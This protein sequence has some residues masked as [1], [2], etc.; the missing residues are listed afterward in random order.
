ML[1]ALL[2]GALA[3]VSAC[4][5]SDGPSSPSEPVASCMSGQ[6]TGPYP[7]ST[8][9]AQPVGVSGGTFTV[10]VTVAG[11]CQWTV[12]SDV[13]WAAVSG[14]HT[15]RGSQNLSY[16]VPANAGG[17]RTGRLSYSFDSTKS[18]YIVQDGPVTCA[19]SISPTARSFHAQRSAVEVRV[20]APTGCKWAFEG[21]GSWLTVV[22]EDDRPSPWGDGNG[23][24]VAVASANTD[25][26][27]RTGTA[28][29]AGTTFTATQDGTAAPACEYAFM[30]TT[31]SFPARGGSGQVTVTTGADC[32]WVHDQFGDFWIKPVASGQDFR[33]PGVYQ[34]TVDAN[35]STESRSGTFS[36]SGTSASSSTR[37]TVQQAGATCVYTVSPPSSTWGSGGGRAGVSVD[38]R[39]G[40]CQW[41]AGADQSWMTILSGASGTGGGL[42]EFA[43][44]ALP[45]G[46]TSTRTGTVT[47]RGV[48]GLN[49]PAVHAVTQS[50][51]GGQ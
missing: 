31:H 35:Y 2:S 44:S 36:L 13:P 40:S 7:G 50:P 48:S 19:S 51:S 11:N 28:T 20:F 38:A 15:F 24:V 37:V 34:F 49:P 25:T 17:S 47:V 12:T 33:G 1:A 4:D 46:T 41:T 8:S 43:V 10:S 21:N 9:Q 14:G 5:D 39:P 6:L 18:T 30:P 3:A 16:T 29:I 27:P 42:L 23:T 26:G 45:A 32:T 22:P